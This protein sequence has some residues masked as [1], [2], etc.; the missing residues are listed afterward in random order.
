[1]ITFEQVT[2][3]NLYIAREMINSNSSYFEIK[4]GEVPKQE[5]EMEFLT[6]KKY[7]FLIK[8]EDSY[9][10]LT[11]YREQ[12]TEKS[13]S[14]DLL[15]IHADYQG[16]GYGTTAYYELENLFV[17]QGYKKS[18]LDVSSENNRA[19]QFWERNGYTAFDIRGSNKGK[20]MTCYEKT[21]SPS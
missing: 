19:K 3:E 21:L 11:S 8:V 9:I 13:I 20:E 2:K 5:I 15:I 17:Q 14:I 6:S 16:F 10:G 7:S 18:T 1:M 12:P 4:Y